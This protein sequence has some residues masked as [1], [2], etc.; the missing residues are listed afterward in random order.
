MKVPVVR[1]LLYCAG[2][3]LATK[4]TDYTSLLTGPDSDLKIKKLMV[5]QHRLMIMELVSG[6]HTDGGAEKQKIISPSSGQ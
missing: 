1:T 6:I 4:E 2:E 5:L 3:I